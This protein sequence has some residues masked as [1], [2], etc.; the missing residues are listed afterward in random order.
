MH[1]YFSLAFSISSIHF[2]SFLLSFLAASH[3]QNDNNNNNNN[4]NSNNNNNN[5]NNLQ[6]TEIGFGERTPYHVP[7]KINRKNLN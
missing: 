1:I 6:G 2:L 4:N 7:G 3:T 5:N